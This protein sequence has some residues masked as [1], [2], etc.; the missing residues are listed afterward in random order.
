MAYSD[1]MRN[2]LQGLGATLTKTDRILTGKGKV[3]VSFRSPGVNAPSATDG[4]TIWIDPDKIDIGSASGLVSVLGLNYH[5]VCH[6]LF[7]PRDSDMT[8]RMIRSKSM[9]Q[10]WNILED[11]RI[12]TLFSAMYS[13]A[14]KFF[15]APVVTYLVEDEAKW[16]TAH[17][18]TYGRRFLPRAIRDEFRSQFVGTDDQRDEAEEIIDRYRKVH[19]R[20]PGIV[21]DRIVSLVERFHKL[22]S[23]LAGSDAL[24]DHPQCGDQVRKE[25]RVDQSAADKA[26]RRREEDD[27]AEEEENDADD[28]NGSEGSGDVDPED[29]EDVPEASSDAEDDRADEDESDA[30]DDGDSG[31]GD[32][33]AGDDAGDQSGDDSDGDPDDASDQD[34]PSGGGDGAP[35]GSGDDDEEDESGEVAGTAAGDSR[36]SQEIRD[37]VTSTVASILDDI[38]DD[39]EVRNEI[40]TVQ[41]GMDDSDNVDF[42]GDRK[43][44]HLVP[45]KPGMV[46]ASDRVE[47]ELRRL[48]EQFEAGWNRGTDHGVLNM[49][50]AM[51]MDYDP[52]TL[53]DTWEEGHEEESGVEVVMLLDLSHSMMSAVE[54]PPGAKLPDDRPPRIESA[55]A[56][57]WILKHALDKNDAVTSVLGFGTKTVKIYGRDDT[58][59]PGRYDLYHAPDYGTNP[60]REIQEAKRIL[61]ASDKP[62][63]LFIAI[64]DGEIAGPFGS[65][66]AP[67]LALQQVDAT[68]MLVQI[69]QCDGA[70][71][72]F[73]ALCD[74]SATVFDAGQLVDMVRDTVTSLLLRKLNR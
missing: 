51:D 1:A 42:E 31:R 21:D 6:I 5:E 3:A 63:R 37:D 64:T 43:K 22:L 27:A 69:G 29:E 32:D 54:Y 17:L 11:A 60:T 35:S 30:S 45:V 58:V 38:M 24:N 14:S 49:S 19:Y 33:D 46:S 41:A 12:E 34:G 39:A 15:T 25:G 55:C 28:D 65:A 73:A 8:L 53:Y 7:S 48:R 47:G 23:E 36:T 56:A 4:K 67:V 72:D 2:K 62:N 40:T 57:M 74:V 71:D 18:V 59:E 13:Q 20:T 70:N 9:N 52:D 16:G 66:N 68:R 44:G 50:R 61:D 26:S 10:A